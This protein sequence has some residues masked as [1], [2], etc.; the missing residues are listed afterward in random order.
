MS[1]ARWAPQFGHSVRS[2]AS[3]SPDS[4]LALVTDT[5][6]PQRGQGD[7]LTALDKALF[8]WLVDRDL[9]SDRVRLPLCHIPL[10]IRL[11]CRR[12]VRAINCSLKR[13]GEC[14]RFA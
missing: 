10:P 2:R 13:L 5:C 6:W 9:A 3:W 12:L 14:C 1:R 8:L 7:S 11:A 4:I